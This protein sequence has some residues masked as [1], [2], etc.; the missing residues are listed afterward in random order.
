VPRMP[1]GSWLQARHCHDH[2]TMATVAQAERTQGA[3]LF[4]F[5]G[6]PF[7]GG[8]PSVAH[9]AVSLGNGSTIEARN[10][11]AGGGR[12]PVGGRGG[13]HAA[14]VP[15]LTYGAPAADPGDTHPAWPG[16]YLTHPPVMV[17]D[18]AKTWQARMHERGWDIEVDGRYG[19]ASAR[20]C[21]QFQKEKGLRV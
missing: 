2:H 21:R 9:V 6:D 20:I 5:H 3:L 18:D 15:G 12:V 17:G 4:K 13:R 16:R 10:K 19:A 8:R 14:L 11:Q 1:D 7:H